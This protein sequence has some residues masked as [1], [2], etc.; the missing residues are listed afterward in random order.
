ML[1]LSCLQDF[2]S[3]FDGRLA[4]LPVNSAGVVNQS[5]QLTPRLFS[6]AERISSRPVPFIR[7]IFCEGGPG[8]TYTEAP[9]LES[10]R[11]IGETG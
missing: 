7:K 8:P 5:E 3:P 6:C 1:T 11:F 4:E 10:G 9:A 2:V